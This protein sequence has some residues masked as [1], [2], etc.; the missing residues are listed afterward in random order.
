[1]KADAV[2]Q[3][4]ITILIFATSLLALPAAPLAAQSAGRMWAAQTGPNQA[5]L[6][7]DSIPGAMEYRIY[8]GAP[9]EPGAPVERHPAIRLSASGRGAV[10]TG[11]QRFSNGIYL[12]AVDARGRVLHQ[13][14]FN[15][16][17]A[18]TA[19]A[20][21]APP[22]AVTA[23]ATSATEV[24]VTWSAVPGATAY[25]IGRAVGGSGFGMLCALCPTEP[26]YVD[27]NAMA[28]FPHAYTIS[29]IFPN[30]VSRRI[31]S[32]QVTPGMTQVA[33]PPGQPLPAGTGTQ[34]TITQT[35]TPINAAQTTSS[36][37]G[38]VPGGLP[39]ALSNQANAMA[40]QTGA[41][42]GTTATTTMPTTHAATPIG[43]TQTTSSP[44][45]VVPG[46]IAGALSNQMNTMIQQIGATATVPTTH[47]ATPITTTQTTG[48][49]VTT[50]PGAV[51]DAMGNLV[52]SV[53][54]Q[55]GLATAAAG[56]VTAPT[57]HTATPIGATQT[58]NDPL[59]GALGGLQ[60]TVREVVGALG[61]ATNT[62]V[63]P[64]N[65]QVTEV[66]GSVQDVVRDVVSGVSGAVGGMASGLAPAS[67]VNAP[68]SVT[69]SVTGPGTVSVTWQ[70]STTTGLTEYRLNRRING[71]AWEPLQTTGPSTLTYSDTFFPVTLFASG[72]V[73]VSYNVIA[74]KS[75][76]F[77]PAITTGELV[78]QPTAPTISL[79]AAGT[80]TAACKL[81]Y[82]RADNMWAAFGQPAGA[83]GT[84]TISLAAAQD[85]VFITDWKYEKTRND[86]SNYYGSHLRIATNAGSKTIRLQLRSLTLT[87]LVVF[88]R[89]GTDTFWIR[90]DPGTTKQLQADLMEVFCEQ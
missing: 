66:V 67:P 80:A 9:G 34:A 39:G 2:T 32:N 42:A 15:R 18:V 17:A 55:M 79:P 85:K 89:T 53:S 51:L 54:Q 24:T 88:A 69:A 13:A 35:A 68:A 25:S 82:Q 47:A 75:T 57:T 84:E 58:A 4:T 20:P 90:L 60:N 41:A 46:G 65:N 74:L 87:G 30:G 52:N 37:I 11:M 48:S 50:L 12:V 64:T 33:T 6:A 59:G 5:T 63:Q 61:S 38:V 56:A 45:G 49:P 78:V 62:F 44:I 77:S 1:M 27:R 3:C 28:G 73:R 23:E 21:V 83:L 22:P 43:T 36:P 86:G 29:A 71:G 8:V 14:Q 19:L 81:N 7:W 26:R 72:P 31:T 40:Q 16:L 10:I 76:A 70:A